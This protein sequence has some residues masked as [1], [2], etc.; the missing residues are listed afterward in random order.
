VIHVC[1]VYVDNLQTCTRCGAILT[2]YRNAMI[3]EGEAPLAGFAPGTMLD[4]IETKGFRASMVVS[5]RDGLARGLM[6]AGNLSDE[7]LRQV[8]AVISGIVDRLAEPRLGGATGLTNDLK[9]WA[10]A[11]EAIVCRHED[12]RG[13]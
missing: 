1:G 2:D 7:D 9:R 5:D 3:P 8:H 10:L 11:L 6:C 12:K 4:V 13:V